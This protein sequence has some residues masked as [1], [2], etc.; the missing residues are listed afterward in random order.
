NPLLASSWYPVGVWNRVLKLHFRTVGDPA[1]EMRRIA[2]Y[3]ADRD[4]NTVLKF[5]LS[6]ATPDTIVA[7]TGMFWSRYFD[8][9]TLTPS[10]IKRCEWVLAIQCSTD[11]DGGPSLYTCD[12]GVSGWVEQALQLA[13]A[14]APRVAHRQC[15]FR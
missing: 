12:M 1:A 15:R 4:L 2:R 13:G 8:C 14:K 6:I 10:M 7:R 9:G 11:E 5:A 3:V